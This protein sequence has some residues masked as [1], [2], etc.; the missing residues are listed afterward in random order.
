MPKQL[1]LYPAHGP[2]APRWGYDN[3]V[4][5]WTPD[6]TRVLFRSL[7]DANGGSTESAL[8]TVPVDGGLP[9]KLPM[10]TSGA[11]DFSPD[12]KRMIYSPLFRDFRTWKRYQGGWAQDL[13]I[14]DLATLDLTP[15]A[16]PCAPS[17]TPCGSA[18]PIYFVSDRDGTLNLYRYDIA[19]QEVDELTH[20]TVWDVRWASSDNASK[21][22]YELD[23][24]LHVYDTTAAKDTK[25]AIAVPDDGLNTRP[26]RYPAWKNI[27][28]FGLSPKGE[29]ALFVARGDVFTAPIEKGASRN[30]TDTSN[31]HDKW[32]VWSPDGAKI[33]FV[34][35]M[36]GEEQIYL[37]DEKGAGKPEQLTTTLKAMLLRP[38]FSPDG[39]K[40]AFAD[41]NGK[42]Y[43]LDV[44]TKKLTQVFDDEYGPVFDYAF[45]P[46]G[47]WLAFSKGEA[48]GLRA[49][50]IVSAADG[51]ARFTSDPF[52]NAVEPAWDPDGNFLFFLSDREYA[53]QISSLE[54]N[55][56]GNRTTGVF[57][58]ALRKDVANPFAPE[59]DEVTVDAKDGAKDEKTAEAGKKGKAPKAAKEDDKPLV[60]DFDGLGARAVRVP[61]DAD[62]IEGLSA[63]K[64]N[65]FYTTSGAPF[66]GRKSYTD[67]KL[68]VFSM[69]DREAS[70]LADDVD[71]YALSADG[72]KVLVQQGHAYNLY[73]AKPKAKDKKTVSTHD[74]YVDRIPKQEWMEA[75]DEVWRR[76]RDFFYVHNMHG[77]DWKAIGDRY[78]ALVPY[79]AHRSDLNYVLGEMVAELSIGHAYI[80]GGDYDIPERARVGLPGARFELDAASGRYRIAKVFT[81]RQRGAQVPLAA[82][83]GGRG[84]QAGRLRAGHRRRGARRDRQPLPA[85]PVQD[86]PRDPDRQREAHHGGRAE[87]H[88]HA[89]LRRVGAALP[90]LGG[91]Q[92]RPG[93]EDDRRPR[94]LPPH[95]GHGRRGDRRVHQVRSTRRSAR[96]GSSSTSA[97]T[98][99]ATSPSGSSSGSTPSCWAPVSATFRTTREPT[100]T[101]SSTVTRSASSTRPR[102]P[103]ATSSRTTSARPASGRSSASA[104][105]AASWASPAP[106]RSST[107]AWCSCPW[108]APTTRT[109]TGSSRATASTPTSWSRTIRSP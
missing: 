22:V 16:H 50:A 89:D 19:S 6:G 81:R 46:D 52:F 108:P 55:Y 57:A 18:T 44:A 10:P 68:V 60:I 94:R 32:A 3:Q 5:G 26:S 99:A 75:F 36:S 93:R 25:L 29:R 67:T 49:L 71:G 64:G 53:P 59:S 23:G 61:V 38:V 77:Y 66:Y 35:D 69:K 27:E 72:S 24:E 11:G 7:R 12:G 84:R 54:W 34:S 15:V 107:E 45:S 14:F 21:I 91:R 56:A 62:N 95:P 80:Q 88:L 33:A 106:G 70:T 17:A 103:T 78:R 13:Y 104:P 79:V 41:K 1:T 4:Y 74:L 65:L 2:L 43:V 51:T 30:L 87:G 101:P 96:R 100:R 76:Y 85:A 82:V 86:R 47:A 90:G 40:L 42:V 102:P 83:R 8:Y 28:A 105:G 9:V 98:A 63:I 73:D 58:Y 92:P 37:V 31:A 39:G 109:A 97:P 48:S 20:E